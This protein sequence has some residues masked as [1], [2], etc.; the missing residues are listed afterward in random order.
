MNGMINK[1]NN[2]KNNFMKISQV[3]LKDFELTP[4]TCL[5]LSLGRTCPSRATT[6]TPHPPP[7]P[8]E[9][10]LH[11]SWRDY[12]IID[13]LS[14]LFPRR[15]TGCRTVLQNLKPDNAISLIVFV[16][17]FERWLLYVFSFL[18]FYLKVFLF[19]CCHLVPVINLLFS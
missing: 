11:S 3:N 7:P 2:K 18:C 14:T 9:A 10:W 12:T 4:V 19:I 16:F 1:K 5:M 15:A 8:N 13:C 6:P 17:C